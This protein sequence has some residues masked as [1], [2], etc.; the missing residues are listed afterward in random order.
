MTPPLILSMLF[1]WSITWLASSERILSIESVLNSYVD[2]GTEKSHACLYGQDQGSQNAPRKSHS[3]A[4]KRFHAK[5]RIAVR[6]AM[7]FWISLCLEKYLYHE[8]WLSCWL[9]FVLFDNYWYG[10]GEK[11]G[12]GRKKTLGLML[13]VNFCWRILILRRASKTPAPAKFCWRAP[14][15]S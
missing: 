8:N 13:R 10:T 12:M 11:G 9:V 7:Q 2:F 1:I 14:V 6:S 4:K 3:F 5:S 15:N